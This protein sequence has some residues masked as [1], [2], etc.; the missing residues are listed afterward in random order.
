M[1]G[2]I[3]MSI[4]TFYMCYVDDVKEALC[5]AN[6]LEGSTRLAHCYTRNLSEHFLYVWS[7]GR[8]QHCTP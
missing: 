8:S 7:M 1:D 3:L 2:C 5:R 6:T 4:K